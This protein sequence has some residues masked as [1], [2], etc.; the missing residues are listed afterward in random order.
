MTLKTI[1]DMR[2]RSGVTL[3]ELLVVILIVMILAV[4]LLPTFKKFVVQ[5]QYASEPASLVGHIRTQIALYQYENNILP[6]QATT[7]NSDRVNKVFKYEKNN[8]TY[9][10]QE[11]ELPKKS[12][13]KWSGTASASEDYY[14][15]NMDLGVTEYQGNRVAPQHV[16]FAVVENATRYAYAIG[17]FGD[18]TGLP[19]NTGYAVYEAFLPAVQIGSTAS[20]SSSSTD[21]NGYKLVATWKNYTGN[22]ANGDATQILFGQTVCDGTTVKGLC[23]IPPQSSLSGADTTDGLTNSGSN[24]R[25]M[26]KDFFDNNV[27]GSWTYTKLP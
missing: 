4:G 21:Q 16:Q 6:T 9:E 26:V 19:A 3:V 20:G 14:L 17:V 1:Q 23:A 13:A 25:Q 2:S 11:M 10:L 27:C 7:N 8:G 5:A 22:G 12:T 18:G 24:L 15:K